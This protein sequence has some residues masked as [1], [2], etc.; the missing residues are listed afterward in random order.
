MAESISK[1]ESLVR[2]IDETRAA[3]D[4]GGPMPPLPDGPA[5]AAAAAAEEEEEPSF[6]ALGLKPNV[7]ASE[8]SRT[9]WSGAGTLLSPSSSPASSSTVLVLRVLRS[10]GGTGA[11]RAAVSWADAGSWS[12]IE[13][14]PSL[15]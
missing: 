1:N 2:L 9:G 12:A 8:S 11:A 13:L 7:A 14:C 5:A 10:R 6:G 4:G 15:A 3:S